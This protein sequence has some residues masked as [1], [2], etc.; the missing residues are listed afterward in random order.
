MSRESTSQHSC[1]GIHSAEDPCRGSWESWNCLLRTHPMLWV[2]PWAWPRSMG[3][4]F[5]FFPRIPDGEKTSCGQ[6]C[7]CRQLGEG[8]SAGDAPAVRYHFGCH[9][10]MAAADASCLLVGG[11]Q[12]AKSQCRTVSSCLRSDDGPTREKTRWTRTLPAAPAPTPLAW[13]SR[14]H[15]PTT[16]TGNDGRRLQGD[17]RQTVMI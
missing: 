3:L 15:D 13:P 2:S 11:W 16:P 6:C 7:S 5:I 9:F 14:G 17:T 8:R 12:L 1:K 4:D 10:Q